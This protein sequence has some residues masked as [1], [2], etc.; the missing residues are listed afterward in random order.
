MK[1]T[2]KKAISIALLSFSPLSFAFNPAGTIEVV[3]E[4]PHAQ[5][6]N[7]WNGALVEAGALAVQRFITDVEFKYVLGKKC[8]LNSG[9]P[10]KGD[11]GRIW[12]PA[13]QFEIHG[14]IHLDSNTIYA[15]HS[16]R[17]SENYVVM[18]FDDMFEHYNTSRDC[19]IKNLDTPEC[20]AQVDYYT[21][22]QTNPEF[23]QLRAKLEPVE[24]LVNELVFSQETKWSFGEKCDANSFKKREEILAKIETQLLNLKQDA[25]GDEEYLKLWVDSISTQI[26]FSE[27]SSRTYNCRKQMSSAEKNK[28]Y[29]A[30]REALKAL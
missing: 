9:E 6:P 5:G 23:D 7:C 19:K 26:Y 17:A 14:F 20:R 8:R 12:L 30:V 28:K 24:T 21:C 1:A 11:L 2:F 4:G 25:H 10:K 29:R 16:D 27:V 22:D 13:T 3:S 15:K 18:T